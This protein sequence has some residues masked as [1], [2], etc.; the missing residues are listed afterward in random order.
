MADPQLPLVHVSRPP[1]DP[2]DGPAPAVVFLHGFGGDERNM[3]GVADR[4]PSDLHAFGVR[5]PFESSNG[6]SWVSLA[7]RSRG[8][9]QRGVDALGAF[10]DALP[11]AY[12]VDPDSVGLFGFSQGAKTALAA[13][14]D[15]PE[16]Y[17]WAA[18]LNGFLPAGYDDPA[19]LEAARG[20][21][22]FVAV[23]ENDDVIGPQH[24]ERTAELLDSAG[25]DVTFRRYPTGHR[26]TGRE[27]EDVSE[28]LRSQG[29]V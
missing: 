1:D 25:L 26:M 13:L 4:L 10:V 19:R 2:A 5:A 17:R 28:W 29:I 8:G 15:A 11:E 24:G 21:P 3:I 12:A 22:V 20:E 18:A 27:F 16:R 9:F 7:G 23:G 14:V 6:Y